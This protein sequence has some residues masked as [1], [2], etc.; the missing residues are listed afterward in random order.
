MSTQLDTIHRLAELD[1]YWRGYVDG[2]DDKRHILEPSPTAGV[3][4]SPLAQRK[5]TP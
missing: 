3:S 1:P 4:S 5:D 2:L